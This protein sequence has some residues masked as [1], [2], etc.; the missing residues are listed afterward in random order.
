M[1]TQ[2]WDTDRVLTIPNVL[3]LLRMLAIPVFVWLILAGYDLAAVIVLAASAVTDWFDGFLAR[4]L[5]QRTKLGALLDPITDRLYILA[6][7]VALL[8]RGIVPWWFVVILFGRD[9]MLVCLVPFLRTTGR[10]ALP[11]NI[12][13]KAGTFALLLAFPLVLIGAPQAFD[14]AVLYWCG[15]AI[16]MLGAVLYWCAGLLYVRETY[17]L[18]RKASTEVSS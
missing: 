13:G 2:Q 3:S 9:I 17:R 7:I 6:T 15:W 11:V 16:G 12:V 8:C 14:V 1:T 10:N 4:R 5:K 18:T